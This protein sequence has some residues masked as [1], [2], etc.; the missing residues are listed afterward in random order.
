MG[1]HVVGYNQPGGSTVTHVENLKDVG[2]ENCHGPGSP[3]VAE[4][5]KTGLTLRDTPESVCVGCHTH[6]HS[7]RFVYDAFKSLLRVP[8][9]GVPL[10]RKAP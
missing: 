7:D 2:C 10:A 5:D 3:H 4:P 1:C 9:H 8:G 6:E